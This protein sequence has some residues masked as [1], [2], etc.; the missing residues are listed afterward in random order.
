MRIAFI[1]ARGIPHGYSSAE[2]IALNVGKRLV[3][4][5]HN[6]SVYCRSNLFTDHSSYF[7]GIERIFLPSVEHKILGQIIHGFISG[8]HSIF[9]DYDVVHVQCLTNTYQSILPWLFKR[10]IV[11]NVDGQE[12]ENPKWPK[13][14][15]DVFFK[16][17]VYLSLSMCR[18]IITDAVGMYDLYVERYMRPSTIIEYGTDI[19]NS[20]DP[21]ILKQYGLTPKDYY[22]VAAR[23]V[24]SNQIDVIVDAFKQS[25]SKRILALAGGGD[26]K[27]LFFQRLKENTGER[28]RFLGLISDQT[29]M[30]E[31]YANAY[32]Y[33]HGATLGGINSALLRPLGA[34]CPALA[35]NSSFN[36][37][38][39]EMG[40]KKLCGLVWRN[41]DELSEEIRH[42]DRTPS[43]VQELSGLSVK[44]IRRKFTWDL[45]ADQY[46]VFYRGFVERWPVEKIRSEVAYQKV[47]YLVD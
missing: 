45:V 12:W 28:V 35:Y 26:F 27:S 15:R 21:N 3:D 8:I 34:G 47:K 9:K 7:D 23:M 1:G 32:A 42:V 17:T 5:G 19:I 10:N 46:E 22:F 24:P 11:I 25:G 16:S 30:N 39:L 2:Q 37:E 13:A 29:H 20:S 6:F 36:R 33:L 18:E 14:P 44:Q 4:R 43:L 38:V 31:L 41:L 40:D